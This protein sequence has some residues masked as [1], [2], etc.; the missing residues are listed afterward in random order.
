[1]ETLKELD[2]QNIFVKNEIV[3]SKETSLISKRNCPIKTEVSETQEN[4]EL[5]NILYIDKSI[6]IKEEIDIDEQILN[7]NEEWEEKEICKF[8]ELLCCIVN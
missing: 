2:T 1:M 6:L 3:D 4:D 7:I 8:T 5:N